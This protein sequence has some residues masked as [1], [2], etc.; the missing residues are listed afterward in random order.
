L[1]P[2]DVS[3][4][5]VGTGAGAVAAMRSGQLDAMANLDPVITM[6]TQKNEIKIISDTRTLKDT[7]NVYGGNMPAAVLYAP[8]SFIEKN[9][10]TTQALTNAI[11]R[12]L[13]VVTK[14]WAF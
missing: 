6:L 12:A 11:V 7:K 4:I 3:I 5:G 10:N 9:P 2:S 8:I 13:K 14:C 1:K